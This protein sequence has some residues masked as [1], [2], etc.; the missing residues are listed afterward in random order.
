MRWLIAGAA[1]FFWSVFARMVFW[2]GERRPEDRYFRSTT[3]GEFSQKALNRAIET[4][5]EQ[6]NESR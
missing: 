1:G 2:S 3:D 6:V 5:K 4:Q